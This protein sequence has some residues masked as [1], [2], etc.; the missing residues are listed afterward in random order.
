M[1][2]H[3]L[4]ETELCVKESC[5]KL[6]WTLDAC[7]KVQ[8]FPSCPPACLPACL[9]AGLILRDCLAWQLNCSAAAPAAW[10]GHC[11]CAAVRSHATSFNQ[12]PPVALL[13]SPPA[14]F[15]SQQ[16]RRLD[17]RRLR[18]LANILQPYEAAE[19]RARASALHRGGTRI[20]IRVP[21]KSES[22]PAS[23]AVQAGWLA[24]G[25]LV[26]LLL[27]LARDFCLLAAACVTLLQACCHVPFCSAF[28]C[29][30]LLD[31]RSGLPT[32]P[33]HLSAGTESHHP[34]PT[35]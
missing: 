33:P 12:R 19:A 20:T 10:L 3:D 24:L 13:A 30:A 5:H 4:G 14:A 26:P 6:A 27:R 25:C 17:Q 29:F 34:V 2:L 16:D 35:I 21:A 23:T 28:V 15:A 31:C 1:A 32:S 22:L 8:T 9:P 11:R 18:E 7:L